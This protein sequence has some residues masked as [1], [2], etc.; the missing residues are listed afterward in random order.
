MKIRELSKSTALALIASLGLVSLN[1]Y[2]E[3]NKELDTAVVTPS[4]VAVCQTE[5]S[6]K[7]RRGCPSI[8]EARADACDSKGGTYEFK[9]K[10][11]ICLTV[12]NIAKK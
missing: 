7:A 8:C 10:A 3:E 11:Y 6:G 2:A 5:K 9:D 4:C 12:E 1:S